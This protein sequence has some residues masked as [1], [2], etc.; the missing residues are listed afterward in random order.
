MVGEKASQ[1]PRAF[2]GGDDGVDE[3][4]AGGTRLD[5]WIIWKA[6]VWV[7]PRGPD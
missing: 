3:E 4:E 5:G 6:E 2:G 7:A 1:I